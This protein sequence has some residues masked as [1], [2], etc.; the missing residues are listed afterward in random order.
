MLEK[1]SDQHSR[2][3]KHHFYLRRN[4]LLWIANDVIDCLNKEIHGIS[5]NYAGI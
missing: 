3:V 4:A 5:E 1:E 2:V